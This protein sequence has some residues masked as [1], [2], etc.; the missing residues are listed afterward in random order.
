MTLDSVELS[1]PNP[2]PNLYPDPITKYSPAGQMTLDSMV[3]SKPIPNPN[4]HPGEASSNPGSKHSPAGQMALDSVV[5]SELTDLGATDS[6]R[7]L[8]IRVL[9]FC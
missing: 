6:I 1:K 9:R 4:L 3:F 5:L 2:N 8:L 7:V